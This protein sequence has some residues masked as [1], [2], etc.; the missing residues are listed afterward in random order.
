VAEETPIGLVPAAGSLDLDGL[1]IPS[2]DLDELLRVDPAEWREELPSMHE[3]FA[4]FGD[5]LPGELRE[6]L[7]TLEAKVGGGGG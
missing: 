6:Q 4:K 2:E 1:D 3:H 7:D 5:Q